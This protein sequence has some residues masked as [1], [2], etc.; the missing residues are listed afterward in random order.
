VVPNGSPQVS[1]LNPQPC[2]LPSG[3]L[4]PAPPR[5]VLSLRF[6][7]TLPTIFAE[8][9]WQA[10]WLQKRTEGQGKGFPVW[11]AL[12]AHGLHVHANLRTC[13]APVSLESVCLVCRCILTLVVGM[14]VA[15]IR[16]EPTS[17]PPL[18]ETTNNG[19]RRWCGRVRCARTHTRAPARAPDSP[20]PTST[21]STCSFKT[22]TLL[23]QPPPALRAP[24]LQVQP[25]V[26]ENCHLPVARRLTTSHSPNP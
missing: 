19:C 23:H 9:D 10:L 24:A 4:N 20:P 14:L 13:A 6:F 12:L 2:T 16:S 3:F 21:P 8:V 22:V 17:E 26:C 11:V 5:A 1:A 7:N 15:V 18:A 25:E